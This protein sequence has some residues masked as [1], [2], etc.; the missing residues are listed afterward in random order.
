MASSLSISEFLETARQKLGVISVC[1]NNSKAFARAVTEFDDWL[2][3]Q[4]E[5]SL[6]QQI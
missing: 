4:R 3:G 2:K 1:L 5:P 6:M